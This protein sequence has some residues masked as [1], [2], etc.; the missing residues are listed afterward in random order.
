MNNLI[1]NHINEHIKLITLIDEN[2]QKKIFFIAQ[3][4]IKA[5]KKNKTIFWCG[6]GGSSS[7]A[8]HLAAELIGRFKMIEEHCVQFH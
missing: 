1:K 6:N 2:L 8:Q 7:D 5:L 4:I 3:I